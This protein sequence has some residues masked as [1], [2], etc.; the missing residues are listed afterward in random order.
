MPHLKKL[1]LD[2]NL[3]EKFDSMINKDNL[4]SIKK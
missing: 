2:N 3:T 1:A 4:P